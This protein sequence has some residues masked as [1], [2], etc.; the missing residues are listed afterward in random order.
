MTVDVNHDDVVTL[1]NKLNVALKAKTQSAAD[2]QRS[3]K[4]QSQV[5]RAQMLRRLLTA[6]SEEEK[7]VINNITSSIK[8]MH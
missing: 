6:G 3:S 2:L 5:V 1:K 4:E 7:L 8:Y